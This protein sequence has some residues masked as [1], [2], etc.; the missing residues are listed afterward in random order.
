MLFPCNARTVDIGEKLVDPRTGP[1]KALSCLMN[2]AHDPK[3]FITITEISRTSRI[4]PFLGGISSTGVGLTAAESRGVA[5]GEAI[6]DYCV[7]IVP[8]NLVLSTWKN[9]SQSGYQ[10]LHPK[11]YPLFSERQ[12]AQKDFPFSPFTEQTFLRWVKSHS[13]FTNEEI[14]VPA[15]LVYGAYQP[16]KQEAKICPTNFA[17]TGCGQTKKQA[18]IAALSEI[19]ERDAMMIWWLN[20]MPCKRCQPVP[21][22]WFSQVLAKYLHASRL[23]FELWDISTDINISCFFGLLTDPHNKIVS[24]GFACRLNPQLTALKA[25]YECLQNRLGVLSLKKGVGINEMNA[26]IGKDILYHPEQNK[27]FA[28]AEQINFSAMIQLNM[29]LQFYAEPK[30]FHYLDTI[31]SCQEEILLPDSPVDPRKDDPMQ[32]LATYLQILKEKKQEILCVDITL[33][34]MRELGFIVLR[35][36][37]PGLVPNSVT[38]WPYLGN[39][40]LYEVPKKLGFPQKEESELCPAPMPYG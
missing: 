21:G 19:I 28:F 18:L 16:D 11:D 35:V 29:N 1:I 26:R 3:V 36:L 8:E 30:N 25:L 7:S 27:H 17:G 33:P 20:Q 2:G 6:E 24:G 14:L 9:L 37:A 23:E 34:D 13:V 5:L 31:R 22:S 38:A 10:A 4:S 15:A 39:P 12:Y 40:R 32:I